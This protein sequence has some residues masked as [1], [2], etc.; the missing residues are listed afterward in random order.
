MRRTHHIF[1]TLLATLIFAGV[2]MAQ[3]N[4]ADWN[5][6]SYFEA[7]TIRDIESCLE[8]GADANERDRYGRNPLYWAVRYGTPEAVSILLQE[9]AV[10]MVV[11]TD[12]AETRGWTPLHLAA[13]FAPTESAMLLIDAGLPVDI[14]IGTGL[15]ATALHIAVERGVAELV[16][17]L[18]D[19][20]A[21]ISLRDEIGDSRTRPSGRTPL[22]IAAAGGSLEIVRLLIRAGAD[23]SEA[24]GIVGMIDRGGRG[25]LHIA[26]AGGFPEIVRALIQE[27]GA[28]VNARDGNGA[29]PLHHAASLSDRSNSQSRPVETARTL[30]M[31][32]ADVNAES[33]SGMTP[34]HIAAAENLPEMVQL[35]IENGANVNARNEHG[36]TPLHRAAYFGFSQNM[37]MF[38]EAQADVNARDANNETPLHA[39]AACA[40]LDAVDMLIDAESEVCALGY[41]GATPRHRAIYGAPW[42]R[43]CFN[44]GEE[45]EEVISRLPTCRN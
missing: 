11:Y 43:E 35:L 1:I 18:I 26:A 30:I 8:E 21:D 23:V 39:A 44:Y 37:R 3:V 12:L 34:L 33:D 13:K 28:N 36:R 17:S 6:Q 14:R 41:Q 5:T 42:A 20:G 2:A 22:H 24:E 4:C 9:G 7:A 40:S 29:T 25:A 16:R 31:L 10:A 15:G 27:G 19:R 32:G 45:R 38:I